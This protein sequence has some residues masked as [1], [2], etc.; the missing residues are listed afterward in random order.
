MVWKTL[1]LMAPWNIVILLQL[2]GCCT[3]APADFRI[4]R[5]RAELGLAG[6]PLVSRAWPPHLGAN[7]T[8][9]HG[10]ARRETHRQLAIAFKY[11]ERLLRELLGGKE[12]V[13]RSSHAYFRGFSWP[14]TPREEYCRFLSSKFPPVTYNALNSVGK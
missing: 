1:P 4:Q 12:A 8:N 5:T 9:P 6:S 13:S 11:F 2:D 3:T 7:D 10:R 14:L